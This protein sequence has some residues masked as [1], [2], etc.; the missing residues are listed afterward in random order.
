MAGGKF[1]KLVG[2]IR[3]GTYINFES[4]KNDVLGIGQR[5]T[6]VLPFVKGDYGP[7]G[8]FIQILAS[9]PDAQAALLGYSIYDE[10]PNGNMLMI[11]EAFKKAN[12]VYVYRPNG[13]TKATANEDGI[14]AT[15]MYEG[16]R[17]NKLSYAVVAATIPENTFD[18]M[19]YMDGAKVA[20]F[21]GL[22]TIGD[23]SGVDCAYM[24]FTG[25]AETEL[26]EN[27]GVNLQGGTDTEAT[28]LDVSKFLDLTESIRWNT[29]CFPFEDH[30][31]Q[32][33]AKVKIKYLRDN[34]GRGVQVVMP[35]TLANDYE[36]VISVTN[37]VQVT[38]VDLTIP[39]TCS[40][41]AAATAAA[42]NTQ[43]NT[44]VEYE[45]ATAVIGPKT[46]EEAEAAIKNGELFF[47]ISETGAVIVEY[48]INTLRTFG[49]KVKKDESYRKNRVIRV[50][51]TFQEALQNNFPPNK[52][53]NEP[54][55]WAIMEGIGRSILKMFEEAGAITDVD[56]DTD[57]KVDTSLSEGDK[58]FFNVG[59]KAVD[60]AEKLFFTIKTR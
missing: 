19:V 57:F 49:S 55:G 17:G 41:V 28:N 26:V 52:Y 29:L 40:W 58:T 44:Y 53:D 42:T 2:K 47:S 30:D 46:H 39:Q 23:L 60:S 38:G 43:S 51:D 25:D 9:S 7:V 50:F 33:A 34:T 45:G 16:T 13:G 5:G 35:N 56:Y 54:I 8:E 20:E 3:P 6:M 12:T 22:S 4:T 27:A 36:G 10:D 14:T 32:A 24:T 11:R 31:L 37:A 15:A 59:L 18:V 48:D 1:D 21:N